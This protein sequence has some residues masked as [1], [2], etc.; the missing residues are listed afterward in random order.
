MRSCIH[1]F[2]M[3]PKVI[4]L[5]IICIAA[6][7]VAGC[8]AHAPEPAAPSPLP[9]SLTQTIPAITASPILVSECTRDADCVPSECCHPSRCTAAAIKQPCNLMCTASCEGP[10]DCG[11]GMCGCVNGNCSVIPLSSASSSLL[12]TTSITIRAS[13]QRYSPILS[14]TPGIG[15]EPVATGFSTDNASFEWKATYGGF[16]SWNAP[17]FKVNQLGESTSNHGGKLYWTFIDKPSSTATPVT[18]TVTAKDTG[19]GRVL[20]TSVAT[21]VWEDNYS[22][23]VREVV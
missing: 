20:G 23:T 14:S 9:T 7:S 13:P 2:H 11:A 1:G 6:I 12:K 3:N 5:L 21:L 10:L 8:T 4:A 15:L 22:V 17:D 19:S 16:L 18:I